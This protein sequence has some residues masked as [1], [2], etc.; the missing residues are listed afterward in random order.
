MRYKV[1]TLVLSVALVLSVIPS[2]SREMILFKSGQM[3]EGD[4]VNDDGVNIYVTL[5]S[6][7]TISYL[8]IL[9]EKIEPSADYHAR[10]GDAFYKQQKLEEALKEYHKALS[11]DSTHKVSLSQVN[12]IETWYKGQ[13]ADKQAKR[14][15]IA[16]ALLYSQGM[17]NY[18]NGNYELAVEQLKQVLVYT[19]D[20]EDLKQTIAQAKIR[21]DAAETKRVET[22]RAQLEADK[23]K[24]N[25]ISDTIKENQAKE[26]GAI[27][28]V[29]PP[30]NPAAKP[31]P[32]ANNNLNISLKSISGTGENAIA[33]I[34]VTSVNVDQELRLKRLD[35][36]RAGNYRI[37]AID[38]DEIKGEAKIE[39]TAI[40]TSVGQ[41]ITLTANP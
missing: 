13:D 10:K 16:S 1:I 3:V 28:P 15:A 30:V 37:R 35:S 17:T 23:N 4:L 34:M 11:A 39:V 9:I 24:E 41:T 20:D 25:F 40:G 21:A 2:M 27:N 14:S 12:V 26:A 36:D 31:Q 8:K 32:T 6:G 18:R 19:P 5:K 22:E 38:I 29:L 33:I 7:V